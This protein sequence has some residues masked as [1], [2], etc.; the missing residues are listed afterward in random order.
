MMQ[1]TYLL[2]ESFPYEKTIHA[3]AGPG[4]ARR[5]K[6]PTAPLSALADA[7]NHGPVI[8]D[9]RIVDAEMAHLSAL[10]SRQRNPGPRYLKVVDPYWE[11]I[12]QPYYRWLLGLTRF[13]NVCFVGPYQ[14]TGM[15]K[16][17]TDLSRPDAYVHLP[18]AYE[19]ER[20]LTLDPKQRSRFLAFTGA[21]H[22]D[23]YPERTA[24][25]RAMRR[26]WWAARKVSVLPHPG[27]PDVG[28]VPK[29]TITGENYL[30]FLAAHRFMYLD[31]SRESLEFLKYSECAYAGCVPVGRAPVTFPPELR[32]SVL[33]L[34]AAHLRRDL[35][36][37]A[38]TASAA[39][40]QTASLYRERLRRARDPDLLNA[41]LIAHYS[42]QIKRL[43]AS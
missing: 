24:V 16:L 33:P 10:W 31:P 37:L 43:G 32:E 9:N 19:N 23:F 6:W 34:E 7:A 40:E 41:E 11:C 13:P 35:R 17:L 30:R 26:H 4:Y 12:R 2:S 14:A 15:T 1:I 22:P 18:Y 20:E 21:V 39:C 38:A 29:H 28:H 42:A 3:D 5:Q 27:Y 25:L 36:Q 8:I